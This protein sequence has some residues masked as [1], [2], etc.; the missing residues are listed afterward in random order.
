MDMTPEEKQLLDLDKSRDENIQKLKDLEDELY[1]SVNQA[2]FEDSDNAIPEEKKD[3][4]SK[5]IKLSNL[6]NDLDTIRIEKIAE[7]FRENESKLKEGIDEL[8]TTLGGI[9]SS[10]DTLGQI[11]TLIS[12]I[13]N[14]LI[15]V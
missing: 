11:G 14:I 1:S 6:I 3:F 2:W 13:A 15:V 7:K 12:T 4:T 8:S 5:R 9:S 10:I